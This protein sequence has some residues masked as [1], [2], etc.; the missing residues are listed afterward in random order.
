MLEDII[1]LQ[2]KLFIQMP[3]Y[4]IKDGL[5]GS[6]P[7]A[8]KAVYPVICKHI[9]AHGVC[10]PS[11]ATISKFAGVT[12]KTVREGLAGLND[13][14]EYS[15][16]KYITQRGHTAYRYILKPIRKDTKA[17][18]ISHSFFNKYHWARLKPSGKC[19]Y[20]ILQYFSW[21]DCEVYK[22]V[23]GEDTLYDNCDIGD[24]PYPYRNYD[25]IDADWEHIAF[26][27]GIGVR[28]VNA[29]FE[30][31]VKNCFIE[32]HGTI[33]GRQTWKLFTQPL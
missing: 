18:S 25:F 13:F 33:E 23:E 2:N 10:F 15:R 30:S 24:N 7:P 9:N 1:A 26:L 27:S 17:I 21:W 16:E 8:S 28:S 4:C 3:K 14:P 11:E 5:W 20:P 22:E 29:A 31:L 6:L 32:Y 12:E 19:I